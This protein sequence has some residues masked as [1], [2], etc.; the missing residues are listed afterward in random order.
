MINQF[1]ILRKDGQPLYI[2]HKDNELNKMLIGGF[3]SSFE[4]FAGNLHQTHINKIE[5]D[6]YT[7]FYSVKDPIISIVEAKPQNDIESKVFQ[8]TAER[9]AR[10]FIE[11]YTK[12]I[13][14]EWCG[15]AEAFEDFCNI[16]EEISNNLSQLMHQKHQDFITRYFVEAANDENI[17]GTVVFDLDKDEIT[18]SDI[19]SNFA[20]KD[21]EAFGSML[22][23]FV[24]R[25]SITL[26]SGD[27]DEILLRAKEYWIGGFRKRNF[28]VFMIFNQNYFGKIL[29]DFVKT[30][31]PE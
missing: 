9:L 7:Y 19:P 8:I 24:N 15:N 30:A 26:K 11:K 12:P 23:S 4:M 17:L 18:V 28:A 3:L 13:L 22:F 1:M 5:L 29:P 2:H 6:N 10:S 16:Y 31:I 14:C 20:Y 27:I 21:F 25:L